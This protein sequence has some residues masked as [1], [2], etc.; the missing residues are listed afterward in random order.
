MASAASSVTRIPSSMI[1]AAMLA[2]RPRNSS[3]RSP[4]RLFLGGDGVADVDPGGHFPRIP[5]EQFVADLLDGAPGRGRQGE[6]AA[7]DRLIVVD[8]AVDDA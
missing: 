6:S 5:L 4:R 1:F 3:S 7:Q 8:R 2:A